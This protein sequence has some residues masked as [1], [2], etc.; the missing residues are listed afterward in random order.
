MSF[1]PGAGVN[2]WI[3]EI[4]VKTV[5]FLILCAGTES[6]YSQEYFY[7]SVSGIMNGG[8]GQQGQSQRL[9]YANVYWVGGSESVTTDEFGEFKIVRPDQ[10]VFDL[11]A[12][13]VGYGND[14][15]H[16]DPDQQRAEFVLRAD[17]DLKEVVISESLEGNYISQINPI[18]TE[19]ITESGL[20]KL[21]AATFRKVLRTPPLWMLV[22]QMQYPVPKRSRCWDYP[23]YI[24][25][26]SRKMYLL[27]VVWPQTT[28]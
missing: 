9:S 20:Q 13:F 18:K 15:I 17:A 1:I 3:K 11:V 2:M 12:G 16:V 21:A 7:G 6:L 22:I 10:G 19:I 4:T 8:Q 25:S 5:I 23:A 28:G 14:T 27:S 26:C 24:P